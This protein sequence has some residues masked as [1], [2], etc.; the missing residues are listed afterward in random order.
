MKKFF[1]YLPL[2]FLFI[3]I[4]G[5]NI[6]LGDTSTISTSVGVF[7]ITTIDISSKDIVEKISGQPWWGNQELAEEFA[8]LAKLNFGTQ[9]NQSC[10]AASFAFDLTEN[11]INEALWYQ[12]VEGGIGISE[13]GSVNV[14]SE[15]NLTGIRT[16]A[17]AKKEVPVVPQQSLAKITRTDGTETNSTISIGSSS[18]NGETYSTS[19]TVD[20]E[21]TLTAKIYPDSGDVGEEGELYVV[22]RSTIDGKK[23]FSAL[24]EDGNWEPWNASLKTLPAAKYIESLEEVEDI[25]IY[26]GAITAGVRLFYVG[27][28]L[29]TEDGKPVITTSLSPY[30]ITVSE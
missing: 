19:F 6:A 8:N 20:D 1:I 13:N 16:Y 15:T 27:Y 29:F 11:S 28:S 23:T 4:F 21:V 26:S 17:I 9:Y 12:C 22:M 30:K 5:T 24:N 25:L 14:R 7:T 18:D 3:C 10:V 2:N